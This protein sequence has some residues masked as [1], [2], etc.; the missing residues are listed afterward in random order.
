MKS[1]DQFVQ[2]I[3]ESVN[4]DGFSH[5]L[6][7][8]HGTSHKFDDFDDN[9]NQKNRHNTT[10]EREVRGH[11]FTNDIQSAG[12]Y[13]GGY[14]GRS[15]KVTGNKPRII[16]AHLKMTNPYNATNEIKKHQKAGLS[17][18]DAK[19]KAYM[20][21]DRTKHDGVY[22]NGSS[23][24]SPEYV[25]FHAKHILQ[26]KPK[27]IKEAAHSGIKGWMSPTGEA[28]L[29]SIG[30]EHHENLPPAAK[31]KI[32]SR[33]SGFDRLTDAQKVGY[34]RFGST[35][36]FHYIHYDHSNLQGRKAAAHTMRYLKPKHGETIYLTKSPGIT[37]VS[38]RSTHLCSKRTSNLAQKAVRLL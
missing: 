12:G 33:S 14:A 10:P 27:D 1:F 19:N 31:K 5:D 3:S 23:M 29:F 35:G 6:T 9:H 26:I 37:P 15:A 17:F 28:H 20:N 18:S 11:F 7:L 22:H 21:V 36:D 30:Q 34:A 2:Y 16:Q 25:A 4:K 24:N 8:Y 38:P 13:A 32:P